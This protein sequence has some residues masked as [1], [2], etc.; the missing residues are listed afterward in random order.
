MR[1]LILLV[2]VPALLLMAGCEKEVEQTEM[3]LDMSKQ[4]TVKVYLYAQLDNT[5]LGWEYVPN[6][7][8]VLISIPN[9][10]FNPAAPGNWTDSTVVQNG[11]VEVMVPS[12]TT[13]VTVTLTPREFVANQVQAYG[14]NLASIAKIYKATPINVAVK[15]GEVRTEELFYNPTAFSSLTETVDLNFKLFADVDETVAGEVV[16]QGTTLNLYNDAWHTTV[17]VGADGQ[18]SVSVPKNQWI[19]LSFETTK[20]LWDSSTKKYKYTY[21]YLTPTVSTPVRIELDFL[22]GQVWE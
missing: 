3:K 22:F 15:A 21:Q 19:I 2:F 11:M 1:K 9:S 17:T 10:A 7:T 8:P 18:V 16:P 4:A 12:T 5:Q 6:G 14:S 20:K 13:G